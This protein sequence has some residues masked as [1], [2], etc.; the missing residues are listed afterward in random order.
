VKTTVRDRVRLALYALDLLFSAVGCVVDWAVVAV[1][2]LLALV[3]IKMPDAMII[4]GLRAD[5]WPWAFT[6]LLA[7]GMGTSGALSWRR[8]VTV[9]RYLRGEPLH[10]AEIRIFWKGGAA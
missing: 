1:L 4:D 8:C 6:M 9:V 7:M 5:A 10:A 3:Q 2:M